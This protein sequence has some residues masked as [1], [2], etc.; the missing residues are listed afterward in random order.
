MPFL[1]NRELKNDED[2]DALCV[3]SRYIRND[4]TRQVRNRAL[5]CS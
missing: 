1:L 2:D 4:M 3:C 5:H